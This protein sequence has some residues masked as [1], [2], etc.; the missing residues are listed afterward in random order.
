MPNEYDDFGPG[1]M[2]RGFARLEKQVNDLAIQMSAA[3]GPVSEIRFRSEQHQKDI[4]EVCEKVRALETQQRQSD[5]RAAAFGGGV[6]A[7]V[8]VAK[9]LIGSLGK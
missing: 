5:L 3:I 9:F 2:R 1:E 6:S 7:I 8:L 4:D